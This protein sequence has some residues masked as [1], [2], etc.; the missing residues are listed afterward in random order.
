M[1]ESS[2][3]TPI[4][5][6]AV[7][8]LVRQGNGDFEVFLLQ[9]EDHSR[10]LYRKAGIGLA[11][12]DFTRL[13][14]SGVGYVHV[15]TE[16]FHRCEQTIEAMLGQIVRNPKIVPRDKLQ[17]VHGAGSS[18]VR[19]L[20]GGPMSSGDLARASGITDHTI[21][22]ILHDPAIPGHLLC[23]A[24]HE[25]TVA[26]HMFIVA[27]LGVL[28]GLDVFGAE[29]ESVQALGLAGMLHDMGK[30]T[31]PPGVL[32]K[33]GPLTREETELIHQHP[34]ESVRLVGE[35]EHIAPLVRT[36]ILQHHERVDGLGYPIGVKGDELLSESRMLSI[37]DSFHAMIGRR[38]YR[39]ALSVDEATRVLFSQAGKQFDR[40]LLERWR[41]VC[42]RHGGE[43]PPVPVVLHG[44]GEEPPSSK[45][46]HRPASLL[47]KM[48]GQR[49]PRFACRGQKIV[50]CVLVG[51]LSS[52]ESVPEDFS[53]LV[54]DVSRGGVC[55]YTA[56]PL[57]RGEVLCVGVQVED[58]IQW[59]RGVVAWCRRQDAD[60]CRVG[61]RFVE[62]IAAGQRYDLVPVGTLDDGAMRAPTGP[63]SPGTVQPLPSRASSAPVRDKRQRALQT[64]A[65]I[66]TRGKPDA[67][68]QR[69]A[70]TLA[71]SGDLAVRLK[72]IET[73]VTLNTLATREALMSLVS[74]RQPAIR[75]AA[76]SAAGTLKIH[77]ARPEVLRL[78]RDAVPS[79]RLR[80]AGA[81]GQLGDPSG[82][83]AV[84]RALEEDEQAALAV[85]AFGEITETRFPATREGIQ[86]A[87]RYAAA[88]RRT[89]L[90]A[91]SLSA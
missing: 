91:A 74:D 55:L 35:S 41:V 18:V 26:S 20:M 8:E 11:Q 2:H 24:V 79:V 54:H 68:A 65:A 27:A 50:R 70:I 63:A 40:E 1:G 89:L 39:A 32:N 61:V 14:E 25:R 16:D 21:Q 78:L 82:L 58:G 57:Y 7:R 76:A 3:Y 4:P 45:H 80:A 48:I 59:V 64:L 12:P 52:L 67:A 44:P 75:E 87:R 72:A 5:L 43:V 38:S 31:I 73:L 34:V 66:A 47:P 90:S 28:L 62:R 13:A 84:L 6:A 42:E 60:V 29:H 46:E 49:R 71:L 37:V 22:C 9:P 53:S 81:L 51:R 77:E 86:S 15:R 83:L 85:W 56:Y 10:V 33:V 17:I 23:M 30:L 88:K 36:I 19:D 69:K